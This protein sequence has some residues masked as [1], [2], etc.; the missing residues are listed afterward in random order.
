MAHGGAAGLEQR[1]KAQ[2]E[3]QLKAMN[4]ELTETEL[5]Q[6]HTVMMLEVDGVP[7]YEV[8]PVLGVDVSGSLNQGTKGLADRDYAAEWPE[9]RRFRAGNCEDI[10]TLPAAL[11]ALP[12]LEALWL[13]RCKIAAIPAGIAASNTLTALE[14]PHNMLQELPPLPASLV[15]LDASGNQLQGALALGPAASL[16]F[17][18][19]SNNKLTEITGLETCAALRELNI[20]HNKLTSLPVRTVPAPL[21]RPLLLTCPS[22]SLIT[23]APADA[24]AARRLVQPAA[25][26]VGGGSGAPRHAGR[27]GLPPRRVPRRRG[28]LRRAHHPPH[29]R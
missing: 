20:D 21:P 9:L 10:T 28:G 25:G 14:V 11:C 5:E 13:P 24:E 23:G 6:V 17:L 26:R 15:R 12:N 16:A 7:G 22:L 19:V 8:T 27:D 3:G 2:R 1:S 18:T 4:M 29:G